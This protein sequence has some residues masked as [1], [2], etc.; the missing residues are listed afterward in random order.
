MIVIA[1]PGA[2]ILKGVSTVPA[3]GSSGGMEGFATLMQVP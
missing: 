2:P 3:I 1:M